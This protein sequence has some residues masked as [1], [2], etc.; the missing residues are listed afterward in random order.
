MS[1]T[2]FYKGK[3]KR[4]KKPDEVFE[5]ITK[6]IKKKG[7]TK[8]W[9][10]EISEDKSKLRI[11]FPGGMSEDFCLSFDAKGNFNDFCKVDFP[12]EGELFEDGKSEFKALL[13]ALY[14]ARKLFNHIEISD[15][16]ELAAA[17]WDSKHIKFELRE[18]TDEEYNRV[19]RLYLEGIESHEELIWKILAEDMEIS[20]EEVKKYK[21]ID[22]GC[23]SE[24]RF[25]PSIY[26]IAETYLYETSGFR[27]EGRLCFMDEMKYYD[28]GVIGFSI[29]AFQ[30]CLSWVMFDGYGWWESVNLEKQRIFSQKDAQVGVFF[31]ERFAPLFIKE[32]RLLE[33]CLLV[34][35]YIVSVYEYLGFNFMGRVKK[36][37]AF[38]KTILEEY[39]NEKGNIYLTA[40]CTSEKYIFNCFDKV[41][42]QERA[43]KLIYSLK[44]RYGEE[45]KRAYLEFKEKY[46]S[47][48]RFRT[49]VKNLISIDNKY[50]DDTLIK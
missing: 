19:K 36:L 30:Q 1:D 13:D 47:N 28:L 23:F 34:Y 16:Y 37:T 4:G 49:E 8:D 39:E 7:P 29:F 43:A 44:E 20:V 9:I 27:K 33:R 5:K 2:I 10:C 32:E 25:W 15:D 12:L 6:K 3:L 17:Y 41:I 26:P 45:E 11:I 31:R 42:K 40:F 24:E 38:Y 14:N 48:S 35:R 46:S 50:I 21:N 18:L 22:V